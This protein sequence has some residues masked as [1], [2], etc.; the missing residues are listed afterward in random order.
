MA[1]VRKIAK[2]S[3]GGKSAR[4][5]AAA[6]PSKVRKSARIAAAAKLSSAQK[7]LKSAPAT[8]AAKTSKAQKNGKAKAKKQNKAKYIY[9]GTE[10]ID[11]GIFTCFC[12]SEIKNE[13]KNKSSHYTKMH[14]EASAYKALDQAT[15]QVWICNLAG[16]GKEYANWNTYLGHMRAKHHHRGSSKA[17]RAAQQK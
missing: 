2:P 14:N 15:D 12:G 7:N 10:S 3:K 9:R 17:L 6:K 11:T 5:T 16:C 13:D 8:A 1:P 4:T